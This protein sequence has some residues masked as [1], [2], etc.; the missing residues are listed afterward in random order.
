MQ[1]TAGNSRQALLSAAPSSSGTGALGLGTFPWH[2][3]GPVPAGSC[4]SPS[5]ARREVEKT[6][7]IG[8]WSH[9]KLFLQVSPARSFPSPLPG[10]RRRSRRRAGAGRTRSLVLHLEREDLEKVREESGSCI[11][12]LPRLKVRPESPGPLQPWDGTSPRGWHP[13][14]AS[15]GKPPIPLPCPC[16]GTARGPS[17]GADVWTNPQP[18]AAAGREVLG[19]KKDG[20]RWGWT[21]PLLFGGSRRSPPNAD[22][23]RGGGML[24]TTPGLSFPISEKAA[25]LCPRSVVGERDVGSA[26]V[27]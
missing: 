14:S 8:V 25:S 6:M 23:L 13:S 3:K 7:K 22:P 16:L 15:G 10:E 27:W 2:S 26:W 4:S 5:S 19:L 17:R 1:S 24:G 11:L 9:A 18:Q 21:R 20:S 12:H